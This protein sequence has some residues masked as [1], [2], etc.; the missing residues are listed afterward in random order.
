MWGN[1]G[2][3]LGALEQVILSRFRPIYKQ[4]DK[5]NEKEKNLKLNKKYKTINIKNWLEKL[6]KQKMRKYC[7]DLQSIL[8]SSFSS[9][10]FSWSY[11]VGSMGT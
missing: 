5:I 6:K 8:I 2:I 11:S 9:L 7:W 3:I 1:G 10:H 4:C